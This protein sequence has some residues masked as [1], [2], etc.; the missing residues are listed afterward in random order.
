MET[1]LVR[2]SSAWRYC[3]RIY[4]GRTGEEERERG[5]EQGDVA[6]S[7]SVSLPLFGSIH[8]K[9]GAR[10]NGPR[11]PGQILR[12]SSTNLRAAAVL[13]LVLCQW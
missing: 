12:I 9:L 6:V 2:Y 13:V 10:N 11:Y 3:T 7:P 4:T 1:T 8:N 5:S